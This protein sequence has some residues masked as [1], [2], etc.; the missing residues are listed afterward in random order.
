MLKLL[1]GD[2]GIYYF[3][4][5]EKFRIN[6]KTPSG[7]TVSLRNEIHQMNLFGE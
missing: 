1:R 3:W 4:K 2:P 7:L 6:K 5:S